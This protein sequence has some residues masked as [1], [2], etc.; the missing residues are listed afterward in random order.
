M[1][2][3]VNISLGENAYVWF[4]SDFDYVLIAPLSA[5]LY[6][7]IT[8]GTVITVYREDSHVIT[9]ACK[10]DIQSGESFGIFGRTHLDSSHPAYKYAFLLIYLLVSFD[11]FT[12]IIACLMLDILLYDSCLERVLIAG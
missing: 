3:T 8:T 1:W 10:T 9:P 11:H 6:S 2:Y 4:W 7:K 5:A 12:Q